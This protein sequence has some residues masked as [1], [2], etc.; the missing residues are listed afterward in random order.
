M[1]LRTIPIRKAGNR[2]TLFMGG[3]REMVMMSALLAGAMVF[4]AQTI[5]STIFGAALWV[6]A[7]FALRLMAKADPKMRSV[8]MRHRL[9]AAYYPARSSPFRINAI[10]QERQYR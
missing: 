6:T 10:T 1:A 8:Y 7:L 3:D 5:M 2:Q 4:T 9:Y